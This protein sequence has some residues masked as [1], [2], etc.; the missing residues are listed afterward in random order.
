MDHKTHLKKAA[1]VETGRRLGGAEAAVIIVIVLTA[2]A[3][4][5]ADH[6]LE[7]VWQ[8]VGGAGLLGCLVLVAAR[9]SVRAVVR[10]RL[11]VSPTA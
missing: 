11:A 6:P 1:C 3:L 4:A 10:A 9:A 2:A 8:V 5:M 7:D